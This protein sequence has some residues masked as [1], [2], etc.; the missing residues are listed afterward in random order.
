M[1]SLSYA[2]SLATLVALSFALSFALSLFIL[3]EGSP[4]ATDSTQPMEV[5]EAVAQ[6]VDPRTTPEDSARGRRT[7]AGAVAL[8]P[9]PQATDPRYERAEALAGA[10][11]VDAQIAPLHARSEA[12]RASG[13][14]SRQAAPGRRGE[15]NR[16]GVR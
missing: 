15:I 11:K 3:L 1:K 5:A 12:T 14:Q 10:A 4:D 7:A 9:Q 8:A 16:Q 13:H 2:A 6:Y